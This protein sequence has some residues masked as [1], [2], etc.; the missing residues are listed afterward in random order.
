MNYA[1]VYKRLMEIDTD[2]EARAEDHENAADA[3]YR[4]KRDWELALAKAFLAAEGRNKDEREARARLS[5]MDAK[6]YKDFV[7][8]EARWEGSKAA[9]RTLETRAS[10]CQSLLRVSAQEA[11]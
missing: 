6:D 2:L 11:R 1:T 9:M 4:A 8:A 7:V 3:F 10:I 5:L